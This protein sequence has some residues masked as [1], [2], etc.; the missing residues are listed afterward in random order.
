MQYCGY[1]NIRK[2]SENIPDS[3]IFVVVRKTGQ[4]AFAMKIKKQFTLTPFKEQ[5]AA[6]YE[7]RH[8]KKQ[9]LFCKHNGWSSTGQKEFSDDDMDMKMVFMCIYCNNSTF[10]ITQ[11]CPCRGIKNEDRFK[12]TPSG[13]ILPI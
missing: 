9:I 12:K 2:D 11:P 3:E 7:V 5:N 13:I 6:E 4:W 8:A 10:D 1:E